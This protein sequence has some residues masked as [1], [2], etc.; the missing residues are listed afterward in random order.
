HGKVAE[1]VFT[2]QAAVRLAQASGVEMPISEQI[3][4]ILHEN[5]SP[6]DAIQELMTRTAKSESSL[7]D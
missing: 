4:A 7:Q 3:Q 5:K 2:T 1:G 6:R